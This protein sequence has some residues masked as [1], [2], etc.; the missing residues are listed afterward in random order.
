VERRV[1]EVD[2]T[3]FRLRWSPSP[4]PVTYY[5]VYYRR[6]DSSLVWV[7]GTPNNAYFIPEV[8]R[9]GDSL[10]VIEV[11]A[12]G[13]DFSH[14]AHASI[15]FPWD[16]ATSVSGVSVEGGAVGLT[17]HA[18]EPNPFRPSTTIR[19]ELPH[20]VNVSL[21]VFNALGREVRTLVSGRE[22]IGTHSVTWDGRDDRGEPLAGGI[23]F[24]R[25]RAEGDE[26]TRKVILLH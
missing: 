11:E 4:D 10:A 20:A 17:L 24:L 3:T 13:P 26:A 1:D 2:Y 9:N 8:R 6:P 18:N 16:A 23:Y 25:L 21:K 14:S 22:E 5:N 15:Q 7:G 19:Y 12:V